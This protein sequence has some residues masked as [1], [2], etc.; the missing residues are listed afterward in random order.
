MDAFWQFVS[1]TLSS[2]VSSLLLMWILKFQVPRNWQ[3]ILGSIAVALIVTTTVVFIASQIVR[4]TPLPREIDVI[5]ASAKRSVI[6]QRVNGQTFI[7]VTYQIKEQ[8]NPGDYGTV[9]IVFEVTPANP[10]YYLQ[11]GNDDKN[12]RSLERGNLGSEIKYSSQNGFEVFEVPT[13]L[14]RPDLTFN[15][16]QVMTPYQSLPDGNILSF[17]IQKL[18]LLPKP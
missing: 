12:Y 7:G 8:L 2:V 4:I 15:Q 11:I 9:Q 10:S 6:T 14:F 13:T 1:G 5:A 17:S 16:I 3:I 18:L